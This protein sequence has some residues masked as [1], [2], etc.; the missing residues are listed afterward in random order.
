M[1][2]TILNRAILITFLFTVLSGAL[3]KWV[4]SSGAVSNVILLL[5]L[6][7]PFAFF[8]LLPKKKWQLDLLLILAGYIFLLILLAFNPMNKTLYHGFLGIILHTGFWL[9]LFN[10]LNVKKELSL[11]KNL[12]LL[13]LF[14]FAQIGLALVQYNLPAEHF[15]NKYAVENAYIAEVGEA[16]RVTGSFSYISGYNAFLI[17]LGLFIWTLVLRAQYRLVGFLFLFIFPI[18]TLISGSRASFFLSGLISL[19]IIYELF[20]YSSQN[21]IIATFLGMIIFTGN[22][23]GVKDLLFDSA[24]N[25]LSRIEENT[26]DGEQ[27]TRVIGPI[28]EVVDFR[29][30]FPIFGIG[31]GATYQGAV[32]LFGQSTYLINYGGYEEEPERIVLEGGFV[33]FFF[34]IFMVIFVLTKLDIPIIYSLPLFGIILIYFPF[35]FN[36]YNTYFF[37]IGLIFVDMAYQDRVRQKASP[38]I[39]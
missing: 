10:Y 14:C 25:L 23:G 36:T 21:L 27:R 31:L 6:I 16:V 12:N 3:R 24:N 30:E 19:F 28:Q 26:T 1:K 13:I 15:L 37:L 39:A 7:V 4:F 34:R 29:G 35:V 18:A 5:Q 33:L 32:S 2:S 9:A 17:F 22:V 11:P 20:K 8:L 38:H